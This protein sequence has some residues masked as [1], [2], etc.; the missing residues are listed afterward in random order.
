MKKI[1]L[2]L[3]PIILCIVLI[4]CDTTGENVSSVSKTESNVTNESTVSKEDSNDIT[5]NDNNSVTEDSSVS[6]ESSSFVPLTVQK[7]F[8]V[9]VTLNGTTALGNAGFTVKSGYQKNQ[10]ITISSTQDVI[11]AIDTSKIKKIKVVSLS[12]QKF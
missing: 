4:S 2:L 7:E 9:S 5:S 12:S 3:L 6:S 8:D 1:A 11:D 10:K